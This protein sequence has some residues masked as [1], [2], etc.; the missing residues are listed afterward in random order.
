MSPLTYAIVTP[1][2]DEELNLARLAAALVAQTQR[3]VQWIVVDDM[4]TYF[5]R[6]SMACSL[7]V[8]V[9]FL[10]H[11]FV[12][13]AARIPTAHKVHRLQGKH[14][15]RLAAKGLVPDDVLT[16]K[17]RGFFNEAVGPWLADDDG[18]V[19]REILLAPEPALARVLDMDA[20]HA[21]VADWR[22]GD[23]SLAPLLLALIMLE[24]WLG[25]YLPRAFAK[26]PPATIRGAA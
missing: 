9:P 4:L 25:E 13:L 2:R 22:A 14:V 7:E 19:V 17:K 24:L 20:V 26:A 8:R 3:P 16:R 1:A 15:L 23:S 10:D 5:D 18:A 12:E 6:C 21:A 11:E